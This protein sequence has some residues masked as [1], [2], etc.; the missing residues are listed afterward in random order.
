MSDLRPQTAAPR[1]GFAQNEHGSIA[2]E[3]ALISPI[4]LLLILAI[5]QMSLLLLSEQA[6]ENATATLGRMVRTGQ[7]Q[8]L[9]LTPDT[10]R[11]R[12]CEELEPLL[13]CAGDNLYIDIQT[14]PA[15]NAVPLDIP[16]GDQGEFKGT[17]A[18]Q[19]GG[20]GQIVVVRTFYRYPVWIP[21]IGPRLADIGDGLRL[22]S[23]A[24]V[25]R[26]EPF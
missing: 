15:F 1:R 19:P 23:S 24:A 13:P 17:G 20:A 4:F 12:L 3:F 9:H 5:M 18:F 21:L 16:V 14:L 10:F 6:L 8:D 7:A 25:F 22:L 11:A 2:V 26:N